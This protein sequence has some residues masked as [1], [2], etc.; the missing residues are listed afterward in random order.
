MSK[1]WPGFNLNTVAR[2][3]LFD[4]NDNCTKLINCSSSAANQK[5]QLENKSLKISG[6]LD[7][8][9]FDYQEGMDSCT[10]LSS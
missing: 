2:N 10:P 7:V 9:V 1:L 5:E 6:P 3:S 4:N 8:Q